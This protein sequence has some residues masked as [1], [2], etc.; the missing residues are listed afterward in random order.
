MPLFQPLS[1]EDI[2]LTRRHDATDAADDRE[3][4]DV[5]LIDVDAY[6]TELSV[7]VQHIH[8]FGLC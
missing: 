5:M 4:I 3:F 6:A 2:T 7:Q 8:H 1:L